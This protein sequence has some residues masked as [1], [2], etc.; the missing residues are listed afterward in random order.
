MTEEPEFYQNDCP[1][2]N[3]TV[4]PASQAFAEKNGMAAYEILGEQRV[5]KIKPIEECCPN[6]PKSSEKYLSV[7]ANPASEEL[8]PELCINLDFLVNCI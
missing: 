3:I 6:T 8:V 1:T 5:S 7:R 4:K 2:D